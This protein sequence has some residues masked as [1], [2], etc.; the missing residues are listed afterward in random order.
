MLHFYEKCR[1]SFI[2]GKFRGKYSSQADSNPQQF[3]N[4]AAMENTSSIGN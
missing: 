4:I 3:R 1:I 2:T